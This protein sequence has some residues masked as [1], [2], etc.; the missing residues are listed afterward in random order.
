MA[1]DKYYQTLKYEM[2]YWNSIVSRPTSSESTNDTCRTCFTLYTYIMCGLHPNKSLNGI[3]GAYSTAARMA[4][5]ATV[6]GDPA[7]ARFWHGLP[8]TLAALK[9]SLPPAM[10]ARL[11]TAASPPQPSARENGILAA[12]ST[13]SLPPA[14]SIDNRSA[15][16]L[17]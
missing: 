4:V 6:A 9:A 10:K 14:A 2:E 11:A 3:V 12:F 1:T 15:S 17:V 13:S 7:E 5:V 16:L 8:A